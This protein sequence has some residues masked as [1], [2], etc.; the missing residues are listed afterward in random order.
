MLDLALF[1]DDA[2]S[3]FTPV[4]STRH[5]ARQIIGASTL[6]EHVVR[7]LKGAN[8]VLLGRDYLEGLERERTRL[9]YNEIP[10]SVLLVNARLN[11]LAGIEKLARSAQGKVILDR[12]EVALASIRSDD[13]EMVIAKDGTLSRSGL[14]KFAKTAERLESNGQLLFSYPWELLAVNADAIRAAVARTTSNGARTGED[15]NVFLN[16]GAI[17]EDF[18]TL[19]TAGGPV[20]VDKGARIESFSRL[21]GPCYIGPGTTLHSALVREGTTI[22]EGCKVGGEVAH[23]IIYRR[24][25]KAHFGYLGY[26]IVGEWVNIGAGAVT[27]DLKNTY[28]NVRVMRNGERV[29]TGMVKLGAMVGDMAKVSIGTMVYGGRTLGVAARCEGLVDRDVPDF[30]NRTAAG[31]ETRLDLEQVFITQERMKQRR[32]EHL[33][34]EERR[35]MRTI[36]DGGAPPRRSQ[37]KGDGEG[38]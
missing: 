30:V 12:G 10:S 18:V 1:E 34:S 6:I 5:L 22:S 38:R 27:S 3:N 24:T 28:G 33:T 21:S 15:P 17:V 7:A 25:N 37:G 16:P 2:W 19:D 11:P 26:S 4:S 31:E 20:I 35:V 32:D 13:L 29:D 9:P 23:S 36:Y 14:S 8:V